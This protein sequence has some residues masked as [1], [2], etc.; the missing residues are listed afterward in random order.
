MFGAELE[1]LVKMSCKLA[2]DETGLCLLNRLIG[3]PKLPPWPRAHGT[4]KV[5]FQSRGESLNKRLK[6]K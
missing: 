2:S 6:F 5:G 1:E 4:R 3:A